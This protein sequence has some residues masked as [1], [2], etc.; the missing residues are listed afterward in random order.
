[1]NWNRWI[2]LSILSLLY[3]EYRIEAPYLHLTIDAD[4]AN[5]TIEEFFHQFYLSRKTIH[6]YKQ[7]KKY[8]LNGKYVNSSAMLQTGDILSIAC[9]YKDQ[10]FVPTKININIVYEDDFLLIVNKPKHMNVHPDSKEQID[11]LANAA[12]YYL[13]DKEVCVRY[14]HRLDYDTTGL[15]L[16]TKCLFLQPYLDHQIE[17]KQIKRYYKAYVKGKI[18]KGIINKPIARDRHNAKKMRVSDKGKEAITHYQL[19]QYKH[20][21][22]EVE[23]MLETG[24]THQIRVHLASI[25]YP[26]IGDPLY[27]NDHGKGQALHAYKLELIHP[28]TKQRITAISPSPYTYLLK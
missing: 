26:I 2:L 18:G 9:F 11:T 4:Y 13:K 7:D 24:R 8:M 12:A 19:L 17:N 20:G 28:I 10:P 5:I 14:I 1:M 3:M 16:F 27:N 15:V 25:G 21:I 23:C 6:L 22:S